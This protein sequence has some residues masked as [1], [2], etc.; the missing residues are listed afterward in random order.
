MLRYHYRRWMLL[1]VILGM[2]RADSQGLLNSNC[3]IVEAYGGST[4][5]ERR[6]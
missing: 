1:A 4:V 2:R 5:W 6:A 3:A